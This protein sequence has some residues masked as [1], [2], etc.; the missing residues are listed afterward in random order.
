MSRSEAVDGFLREVGTR[1]GVPLALDDEGQCVMACEDDLECVV[2][3]PEASETVVL[4]APVAAVPAVDR[5]AF[6]ERALCL[7]L[8][9][10]GTSGGTL[11]IDRNRNELVLCA[12]RRAAELDPA[13]FAGLLGGFVS[14]ARELKRRFAVAGEA[15]AAPLPAND[16]IPVGNELLLNLHMRA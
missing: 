16:K 4:Y 8:Y 12:Q 11:A 6:L 3:V 13:L 14:A 9:G 7:N 10:E 2:A 5:E 15:A 1:I